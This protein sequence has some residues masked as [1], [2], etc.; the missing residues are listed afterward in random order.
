MGVGGAG[1]ERVA[2]I[3][4]LQHCTEQAGN[5][6]SCSFLHVMEPLMGGTRLGGR[7][8]VSMKPLWEGDSHERFLQ[9]SCP[10]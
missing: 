7:G 8:G 4:T 10:Y 9:F 1:N 3:E 5:Y 2:S 6:E